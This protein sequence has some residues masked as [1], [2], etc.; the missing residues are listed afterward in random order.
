MKKII[1]NFTDHMLIGSH[2]ESLGVRNILSYYGLSLSEDMCFGLGGGIGFLYIRYASLP[3]AFFNGR[4]EDLIE[5][6]ATH[7]GCKYSLNRTFDIERA[8]EAVKEEIN[9]DNPVMLTVDM[10]YFP[11]LMDVLNIENE[12]PFGGH[13]LI[14]IGYDEEKNKAYIADYLWRDI[15]EIPL[16]DLARARDADLLPFAPENCWVVLRKPS[17]FIPLPEA[18]KKA[19]WL[20]IHHN[21]YSFGIGMGIKGL[22]K[23]TRELL[24]WPSL[25][26]EGKIKLYCSNAYFSFEKIGTGGGNFRRMFARYLREVSRELG[27]PGFMN[28]SRLYN[29]LA[30]KWKQ[31]AL[32]LD[33]SS[34]D[35]TKG[36]FEDKEK[37]E[38]L[39]IHDIYENEV[40]GIEMIQKE[41]GYK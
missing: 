38:Q 23:F 36:I 26:K 14:L 20:F 9:N 35:I 30:K 21:L 22:R 8:W 10:T 16:T 1:E 17:T 31:L 2:C 5:T 7:L 27:N 12:Y 28:I 41:I 29:D 18:I 19:L 37:A 6:C 3:S 13:K 33:Q 4:C 24:K 15:K 32:L 34:K 25:L 39:L 11:Y 40:L